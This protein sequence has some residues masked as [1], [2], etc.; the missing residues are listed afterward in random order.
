[1]SGPKLVWRDWNTPQ[2]LRSW[3]MCLEMR[4]TL[5]TPF[6]PYKLLRKWA[7]PEAKRRPS[8]EGKWYVERPGAMKLGPFDDDVAAT[9]AAEQDWRDRVGHAVAGL[10]FQP[11]VSALD[12]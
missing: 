9:R 7:W 2:T 6:G 5:P 4:K 12:H 3:D 1:M 11:D 8:D 10:L